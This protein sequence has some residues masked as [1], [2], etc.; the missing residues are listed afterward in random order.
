MVNE[1]IDEEMFI[2]E[3]PVAVKYLKAKRKAIEKLYCGKLT[4]IEKIPVTDEKTHITEFKDFPVVEDVPCRLF[5]QSSNNTNTNE[6]GAAEATK[7]INLILKPELKVNAGSSIFITQHGV[8][9]QYERSGEPRT[10]SD[11][12]VVPLIRKEL[13]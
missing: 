12:Q 9:L 13:A 6:A 5:Y 10:Y 4:I 1:P 11:H 8:T 2:H 7:T 3:P